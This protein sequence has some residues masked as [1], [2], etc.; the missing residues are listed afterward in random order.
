MIVYSGWPSNQR[1]DHD[2]LVSETC[3]TGALVVK[4]N[5][6]PKGGRRKTKK[7]RHGIRPHQHCLEAAIV[8]KAITF[9]YLRHSKQLIL[10][11]IISRRNYDRVN[12]SQRTS[13]F[14]NCSYH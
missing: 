12:C 8:A 6:Y 5:V 1:F 4:K 10:M 9:R 11:M 13:A 2:R 14:R 7:I 3:P